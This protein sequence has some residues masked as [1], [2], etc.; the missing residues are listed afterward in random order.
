MKKLSLLA[1][2]AAIA[3]LQSVHAQEVRFG[4]KTG[5][6]FATVSGTSDLDDFYKDELLEDGFNPKLATTFN[7]G[8]QVDINFTSNIGLGVGLMLSGKG[9]KMDES[10]VVDDERVSYKEKT[11][12]YYLQLPVQFIYRNSG[13]YGAVGPYVGV[14]VAGSYE[15]EVEYGGDKASDDGKIEFTNDWSEDDLDDESLV[16]SS[17]MA[18][19]DFGAAIELGYEFN[20]LRLTASYN[21]GLSNIYPKDLVES[22]DEDGGIDNFKA[23]NRVIGIHATWMF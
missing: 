7:L 5:L 16:F 9:F 18:P 1:L 17:K 21:L 12:A 22:A 15:W 14:G 20:H 4:V 13:F 8:G 6:N 11:N 10:F 3:L 2:F 23:T 19:L